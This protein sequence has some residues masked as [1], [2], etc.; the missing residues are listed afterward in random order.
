MSGSGK[1]WMS[2]TTTD[3]TESLRIKPRR[4]TRRVWLILYSGSSYSP[5]RANTRTGGWRLLGRVAAAGAKGD[6][7]PGSCFS[8]PIEDGAC[9]MGFRVLEELGVAAYRQV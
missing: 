8:E 2:Q 3:A 6:T 9:S 5:R 4:D 1:L 7:S